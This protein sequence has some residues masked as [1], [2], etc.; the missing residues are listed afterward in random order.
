MNFVINGRNNSSAKYAG[1]LPIMIA[2]NENSSAI[3]LKEGSIMRKK[4][5]IPILNAEAEYSQIFLAITEAGIKFF[6]QS[7]LKCKV[8]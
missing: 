7:A 3:M 5:N 2:I 6:I 4:I 8:C 1:R